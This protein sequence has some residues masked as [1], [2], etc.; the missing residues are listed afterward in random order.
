VSLLDGE[1][2]LDE[3][4]GEMLVRG[5]NLDNVFNALNWLD[6]HSFICEASDEQANVLLDGER[7]L[8]AK[9]MAEL[10]R[11]A[12][13]TQQT[14][15]NHTGLTGL[16]A[17]LALKRAV[18]ALIG[19]GSASVNFIQAMSAIGVGTL[20]VLDEAI[21]KPTQKLSNIGQG[22]KNL[23]EESAKINPFVRLIWVTSLS[24]IC[25]A[26]EN[27]SPD[28]V[29]YCPDRFDSNAGMEI[30]GL[31]LERAIPW[32]LYRRHLHEVDIGPLMIPRETACFACYDSRI[33]ASHSMHTTDAFEDLNLPQLNLPLGVD[34][35]ALEVLKFLTGA[36]EPVAYGRIW[37]L[38]VF[39]GLLELHAVL[40]LPR[41]PACGMHRVRP[42]RKLWEETDEI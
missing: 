14:G 40:K 30:N 10:G 12:E 4:A 35:L 2:G 34:L 22:R 21:E 31:C 13:V 41:C 36:I 15:E 25:T 38:D 37:R 6:R 7:R 20:V 3:I 16:V 32:M 18:V 23:E 5:F 39:S 33:Q 19:S 42:A 29:V 26:S 28:L 8:Y 27:A 9:Q 24:E 1:H 11:W 17:Q